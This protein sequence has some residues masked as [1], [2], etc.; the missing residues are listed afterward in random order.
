MRRVCVFTATR[1]E[2]GLLHPLMRALAATSEVQLQLLVSGSHLSPEFGFTYLEIESDGFSIDERVEMLLSGDTPVAVTKSLG[3]ATIGY[4]EALQRLQP[5]VLVILGDRYEALAAAQ[6]ALL[7]RIPIAHLHGGESSE[8]AV[9][10][11]IRH[12]ITKLAHIHFVAAEPFRRRVLQLGEDPAN[13]HVVGA[14]G[15]DNVFEQQ[16]LGRADLEVT[17]GRTLGRPTFVVTYHPATLSPRSTNRGLHALFDSVDHFERATTIFTMP[18]ADPQGRQIAHEIEGFVATRGERTAAFTS[19]GVLTYLSLMREADVVIGNSSSGLIEAP[20]LHTPTVNIGP[21][22]QGRL[23]GASVIDCKETT[24]A[25]VDAIATALTP[26]FV[27]RVC[28]EESRYG[29]GHAAP[30]IA[31][32]LAKVDLAGITV[33][34]FHDRA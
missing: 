22:Q 12:A 25:I 33:K 30:R 1:A 9:D 32:V 17:L 10:E 8:G 19:L 27:A 34:R 6:A 11:S 5:D 3:L 7:A 15:L 18:N 13:V 29:D 26:E 20:A 21:R 14:P 2:Y 4:A 28:S 24:E 16:L 23:R 31:S